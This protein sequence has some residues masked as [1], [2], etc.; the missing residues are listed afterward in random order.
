MDMISDRS[1]PDHLLG[2]LI[3]KKGEFIS[4][5]SISGMAGVTRSAIWKQINHLKSL[6]YVI[7]S[8]PRKGYCLISS[9]D[10]LLPEEIHARANLKTL[11]R[12]IHYR[13]SVDSTNILAKLLASKGEPHGTLIIAEEQLTGKGRL[14]RKWVSPSGGIWF[15][16]IL[17]P[18]LPPYEA[19]KLTLLAAVAVAQ[20]LRSF[21][22]AASIKWPN[23]ILSGGKKICGILTELSAEIDAVNFVVLGIGLNVNNTQFPEELSKQA[24]SLHN[25]MGENL[26]RADVLARL[27]HTL[28]I[29][30]EQAEREGFDNILIK[31]RALCGTLGHRIMVTGINRTF[32]GV[33]LDIDG[34]GALLVENDEGVV[35]KVLS[36]DVSIRTRDWNK[37]NLPG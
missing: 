34:T 21:G 14:G 11:G 35:E 33:A 31:W 13:S 12:R 2:M 6:G 15:S 20:T 28:E 1:N 10:L 36:G 18:S 29:D 9:P 5:E 7:E 27:L 8:A 3:E 22:A 30:L 17:R 4:G 23:D 32:E 37:T 26:D 16:V 19:P 25:V 24:T